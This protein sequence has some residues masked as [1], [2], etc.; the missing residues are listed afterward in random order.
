MNMIRFLTLGC[1]TTMLIATSTYVA[2]EESPGRIIVNTIDQS[3]AILKD[4]ELQGFD[5]IETRREKLWEAL[6]P[7]FSFE[8]IAQRSLGYHWRKRT[9]QEKEEFVEIFANH[10]KNTYLSKSDTYSGEK[11]E[12]LREDQQGRRSKVQ[13][14]ITTSGGKKVSVDFN[15]YSTGDNWKIYD[16]IIEG[17]STVGNYRTQ[18]NSILSESSFEEL[19]QQLKDKQS[20]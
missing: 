10:L 9:P 4:P 13:T 3:L 17:V 20:I 19:M 2:A 6:K 14:Q 7:I 1:V 5:M 16:I 12:Y 15:M 18:F 8:Q 11:I